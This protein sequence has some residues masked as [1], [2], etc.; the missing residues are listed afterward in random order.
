MRTKRTRVRTKAGTPH[1]TTEKANKSAGSEGHTKLEKRPE[2]SLGRAAEDDAGTMILLD[3]N[4]IIDAH[5][6]VGDHRVRAMNLISSAVI[7]NGAAINCVTL[8]ELY[9]G[10]KRGEDIEEDMR[11]AGVAI[12]DVP[13]AAAAIC[14]RAYRRYRLARRRSGGG[15]APSVP[16]PDFFIGAHA[17]LMRW[18][19]ATR[20]VERYRIYFPAVEL[21]EPASASRFSN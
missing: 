5:Y 14:G 16:L 12:F 4:V 7:N 18:K 19:L 11:R 10:P 15:E 8:A 2:D 6:G 17:E 20:D 21:V 1:D 13:V 3:T 9:A